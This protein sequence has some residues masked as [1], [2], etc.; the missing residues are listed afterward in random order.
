MKICSIIKV[1]ALCAVMF[2]V[3]GCDPDRIARGLQ[4]LDE[5]YGVN[6]KYTQQY[7]YQPTQPYYGPSSSS[8]SGPTMQQQLWC[9]HREPVYKNTGGGYQWVCE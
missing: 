3:A 8:N 6:G 7:R 2:S 1:S 4:T 9:G 5:A